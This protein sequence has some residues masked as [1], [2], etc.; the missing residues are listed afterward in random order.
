[1]I[2]YPAIDLKQGQCVRLEQG[3]MDRATVYGD[4]PLAVARQFEAAGSRWIHMVDLDG[5]IAGS[6]RNREAIG[7]VAA[8]T[9]LQVQAGGGIRSEEDIRQM[10]EV[11]GVSRVI[12][13][14]A[15]VENP[16]LVAWAVEKYADRIAVGID[17][18]GGKV[19]TRGWV[20]EG[21]YDAV[22]LAKQ[23]GSIGVGTIIYTD[24]ARDGMM[25]GPDFA[26]TEQ[27][28]E[29]TG[30]NIIISGGVA[31]HSH[32]AQGLKIGAA[33]AIIGR[34]LYNGAVDLGRALRVAGGAPC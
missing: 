21:E 22:E 10:L 32:I 29:Q 14:T 2:I 4:D 33:G 25:T 12:L 28:I 8:Q 26:R 3:D 18:R 7:K 31:A 16:G 23:M 13:G 34:A 27:L 11:T 15:A 6:A 19:A 5:A 17:A 1:M 9:G 24:I 20:Q 30:L